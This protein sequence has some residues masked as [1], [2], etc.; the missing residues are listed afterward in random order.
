MPFRHQLRVRYGEVDMQ[1]VVFN[2]HYLTYVDE[3]FDA[4]FRAVLGEQY[5]DAD[6]GFDMV[7]KRAELTWHGSATFGDVLAIDVA[8][9]RWGNT[10]FDVAYQGAVGEQ[11]V[12]EA[13]LTYVTVRPGEGGSGP[14]P[15]PV[16]DHVRAALG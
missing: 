11:P 1:E 13:V 12:F 14:R 10:S 2:A 16:P 6:G 3:A 4:W 15:V 8:V 9:R 7:V 5:T